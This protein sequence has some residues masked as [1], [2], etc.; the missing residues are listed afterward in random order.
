MS[1]GFA[2]IGRGRAGART[3]RVPAP[4][5]L[6]LA[7]LALFVALVAVQHPLRTDLPASH[8]F[9][10]EYARGPT[11]PLQIAA[12]AAW[13]LA[14]LACVVLAL[15]AAPSGRRVARGLT[16]LGLAVAAA[17]AGL[18]GV[19]A[20][21]TVGGELPADVERTLGGRLHDLGSLLILA[22]L[23]LAALASLRVLR[24]GRYR[25]SVL[26]LGIV[27]LAVVPVMVA[28]GLD[29]PGV[30]QRAFILM[31]CAWQWRF[32]VAAAASRRRGGEGHEGR[33]RGG[34]ERE[35]TAAVRADAP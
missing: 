35:G 11:A 15:R 8:H 27:L 22:G 18:A 3:S 17:G 4:R 19:F 32:T 9:V 10:S 30:G 13:A 23:L 12:F 16:C 25:L 24:S 1:V 26:V 33:E 28:L 34:H 20:T 29:A 7:G 14:L 31:G 6:A 2:G 5:T 21:E